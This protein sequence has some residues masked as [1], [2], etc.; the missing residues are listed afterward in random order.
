MKFGYSSFG[1]YSYILMWSFRG[2]ECS[3]TIPI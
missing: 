1:G 3:T 2:Q